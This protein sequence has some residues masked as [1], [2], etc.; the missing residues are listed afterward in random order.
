MKKFKSIINS[1]PG[2]TL[3]LFLICVIVTAALAGTNFITKDRI[4]KLNIQA[5]KDAMAE[6]IPASLYENGS[7]KVNGQP[8]DYVIAKNGEEILGYIVTTVAQGYG[9]EIKV[10]AGV[11]PNGD[12]I[13]VRILAA[14]DETPGLGAKVKNK[15]FYNQYIGKSSGVG[16]VKNSHAENDIIA[17]TG[18]TISS[19][20][21]N[22]A[23]N[24]AVAIANNVSRQNIVA[25]TTEQELE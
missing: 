13:N 25:D 19:T 1:V 2:T 21:V 14:D 5:E 11:D 9:G 4:T 12:I 17:V 8:R 16:L 22:T 6:V 23:V 18:A 24:E 10:M 15:D 7:V 20:A 3:I